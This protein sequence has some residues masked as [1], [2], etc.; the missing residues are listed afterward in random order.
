MKTEILLL[1]SMKFVM[2]QKAYIELICGK[3]RKK[4]LR[5]TA[6]GDN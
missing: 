4:N 6:D 5:E 3:K 2:G 1:Y